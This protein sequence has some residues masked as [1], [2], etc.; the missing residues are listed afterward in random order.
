MHHTQ[1][2][3]QPGRLSFCQVAAITG[4]WTLMMENAW[5]LTW[6]RHFPSAGEWKRRKLHKPLDSSF[7]TLGVQSLPTGTKLLVAWGW[8]WWQHVCIPVHVEWGTPGELKGD[9]AQ[10]PL[11]SSCMAEMRWYEEEALT[12]LAS[13]LRFMSLWG[14]L[15]EVGTGAAGRKPYVQVRKDYHLVCICDFL[16]G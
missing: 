4:G 14:S 16:N 1:V 9:Q 3:K 13:Q 2:W 6:W 11:T 8:G 12:V 10:I 5:S 7:S 15:P